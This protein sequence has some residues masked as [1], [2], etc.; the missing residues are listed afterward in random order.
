MS[1][2]VF[3]W[4]ALSGGAWPRSCASNTGRNG[5]PCSVGVGGVGGVAADDKPQPAT[6][7]TKAASTAVLIFMLRMFE[8][9]PWRILGA[10]MTLSLT[11]RHAASTNPTH[12]LARN[13]TPSPTRRS[14]SHI[15]SRPKCLQHSAGRER[16]VDRSLFTTI[17]PMTATISKRVVLVL[18]RVFLCCCRKRGVS[19][20]NHAAVGQLLITPA[21]KGFQH[22]LAAIARRTL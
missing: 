13:S 22:V 11:S 21:L 16:I 7:A 6:S 14:T 9:N 1:A 2:N 17:A 15:R 20:K 10:L 18:S 4:Q 12:N 19:Q 8:P 3:G 5:W